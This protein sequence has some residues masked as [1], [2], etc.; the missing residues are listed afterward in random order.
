MVEDAVIQCEQMR[1]TAHEAAIQTGAKA[2][3]EAARVKQVANAEVEVLRRAAREE[4]AALEKEK[5]A[6]EKAHTFQKSKI[7]LNVG[8]HRFETSLQ[9]L[10]AVPDSYFASM[11]SGRYQLQPDAE[12]G[13]CR[14]TPGPGS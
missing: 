10:R 8:G 12:V 2:W 6:M 14:L 9:T 7:T 13:L 1:A 3:E 11:F 4:R 5:A